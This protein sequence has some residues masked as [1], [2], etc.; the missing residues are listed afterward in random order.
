V[1]ERLPGGVPCLFFLA[2]RPRETG[3]IRPIV[4]GR[5]PPAV[6]RVSGAVADAPSRRAG[7]PHPSAVNGVSADVAAATAYNAGC[8][9]ESSLS[10]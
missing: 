6:D 7:R 5:V 1:F 9:A 3:D 10:W 2:F 4:D 8:T